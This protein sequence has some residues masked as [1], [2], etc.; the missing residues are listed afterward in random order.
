MSV[1]VVNLRTNRNRIRLLPK[2]L[3]LAAVFLG[4][5]AP[6]YVSGIGTCP[7]A[8]A[9]GWSRRLLACPR[10]AIFGVRPSIPDGR[11]SQGG[12]KFPTGGKGEVAQARERLVPLFEHDLFRI[13]L[14]AA[15]VSRFGANPRPTVKVRMKENG[16]DEA[17]AVTRGLSFRV[18]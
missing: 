9:E 12:V 11:C 14:L 3:I 2:S 10:L 1:I 8:M 15:R 5:S 16:R 7:N 18:P 4:K 6:K 17:R 13:M